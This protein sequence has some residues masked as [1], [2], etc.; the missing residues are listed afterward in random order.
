[1]P[2]GVPPGR[3]VAQP[4]ADHGRLPARPHLG[5]GRVRRAS[6]SRRCRRRPGRRP[7]RRAAAASR[8]RRSARRRSC[9]PTSPRRWRRSTDKHP[10][11]AAAEV[12]VDTR[13]SRRRRAGRR[14]VR[15]PRPL[16][17]VR[18]PPGARAGA[19]GRLR[20]PDQPVAVPVAGGRRGGRA[21]QGGRGLR[22]QRRTDDR[23]RAARGARS[24]AGA[25]HR[26]H[27][28]RPFRLRRRPRARPSSTS[29]RASA[30]STR[31]PR[32]ERNASMNQPLDPTPA[33][34]KVFDK[35]ELLLSTE[36][37]LCPGCGEP[38]ALRLDARADP[39]ARRCATAP[40]ASP[41]SAATR[42]SR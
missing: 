2:A 17:E 27:Q 11:I 5:A 30:T 20:A 10:A 35:P 25:R 40:S 37:S 38:I 13:P 22:A 33:M 36:H 12:R 7:A 31:A 26:R 4:G 28:P 19:A 41:A 3:Q 21:R 9:P 6:T 8:S 23:G 14:R 16:R 1:M 24:R 42:R 32:R 15:L 39:G 29:W 34:R 18:R